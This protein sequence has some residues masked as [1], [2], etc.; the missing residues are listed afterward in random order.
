MSNSDEE[1]IK[2]LKDS[3]F[4]AEEARASH[5]ISSQMMVPK[6]FPVNA[7]CICRSGKKYKVCCKSKVDDIKKSAKYS[8]GT[9]SQADLAARYGI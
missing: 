3:S 7:K 6:K 2:S 5:I 9:P 4:F 8:S 1:K